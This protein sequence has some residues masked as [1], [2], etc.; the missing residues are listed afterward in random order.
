[1][2]VV[3]HGNG[4]EYLLPILTFGF[5]AGVIRLLFRPPVQTHPSHTDDRPGATI[6]DV[7]GTLLALI[8]VGF[9]PM[10]YILLRNLLPNSIT[11]LGAFSVD[12]GAF[13]VCMTVA[14]VSA[15]DIGAYFV[16]KS[17]GK[18]PLYP[19]ISPK[20]TLEGSLG[21]G[22]AGLLVASGFLLSPEFDWLRTALLALLLVTVAQLGDLF[23]SLI[24]RDAG[25]KHSS[26]LLASHGGLLDRL[27]S[28]M[29]SGVVSYYYIRWVVL[30]EGLAQEVLQWPIVQWCLH[31]V[32]HWMPLG[33]GA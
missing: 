16:G 30:Q 7:A 29:F 32:N 1:M 31:S 23:E 6:Y 5:I 8:Y 15:S 4:T 10:H 9:L 13:V 11:T 3:A 33:V 18:H 27:D 17:L 26:E 20:K 24:K 21:G 25:V 19:A 2:G 28:Y 14:V 22:L 12:S